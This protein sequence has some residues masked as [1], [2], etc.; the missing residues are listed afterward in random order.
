MN[1]QFKKILIILQMPYYIF[2]SR[3]ILYSQFLSS[4]ITMLEV[5]LSVFLKC[6]DILMT[7]YFP[8]QAENAVLDLTLLFNC[9]DGDA[10]LAI[11]TCEI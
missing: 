7:S 10:F 9:R 6:V 4:T 11:L 5:E 3:N 2:T 8:P 1:Y